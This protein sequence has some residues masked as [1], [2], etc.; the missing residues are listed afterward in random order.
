[1]SSEKGAK[2][3]AAP[4]VGVIIN[5]G[6]LLAGD[7]LEELRAA[8]ADAGHADPPWREVPKSKKAPKKVIEL[9]EK[10]G[11]DRLLVWGG[12]GTVRRCIDTLLDEGLDHVSIG[13][14]PSGTGN[15]LAN[16]LGIPIDLRGAVDVALH[17]D[18]AAIDVGIVNDRQHFAVMA[19]AGFDALL[20]EEADDSGLKDR[21][22]RLGYVWAGI[23]HR[24][25]SAA[26]ARITV[27]GEPWYTGAATT[28][29][30]GNVGRLIGGLP[31][32]PDARPD[33]GRLDV[34]VAEARSA[35]DWA[36]LLGAAA[37]HRVASSPF[38]Q[39]TTAEHLLVEFDRTLPW[40][41][42]GGDRDR[43]DSFEI[44]CL[45][46]AIRV[47]QPRPGG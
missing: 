21:F 33:D 15:L 47:C 44:R 22:G 24:H 5:E 14:L 28:V 45:P 9:V 3:T 39:V 36:R 26:R 42:D 34:G 27:D 16:N 25:V 19:G 4:T 10:C 30:A 41:A 17:G 43:A 35:L 38:A 11:V 29:I 6:K 8:L 37:A 18:P 31:A 1:M 7:G 2:E 40:Q 23:R 46:G 20:I 12:D 13:V 32:F